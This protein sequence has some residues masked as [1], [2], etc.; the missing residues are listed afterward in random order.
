V[1]KVVLEIGENYPHL[2]VSEDPEEVS[3]VELETS[4]HQVAGGPRRMVAEI[5]DEDWQGYKQAEAAYYQWVEKLD[6]LRKRD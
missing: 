2:F 1:K 4:R 3:R 6:N 5:A